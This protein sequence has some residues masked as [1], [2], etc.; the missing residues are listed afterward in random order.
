MFRFFFVHN[1][2]AMDEEYKEK[3]ELQAIVDF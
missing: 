3:L 1:F 2:F